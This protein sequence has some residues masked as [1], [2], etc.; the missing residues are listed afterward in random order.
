L[1][2]RIRK[3]EE[4]RFASSKKEGTIRPLIWSFFIVHFCW[5]IVFLTSLITIQ[6]AI[7]EQDLRREKEDELSRS[8]G[9][10][11]ICG[12]WMFKDIITGKCF[13][14]WCGGRNCILCSCYWR[15][16]IREQLQHILETK[17]AVQFLTLTMNPEYC[18][19]KRL[20]NEDEMKYAKRCLNKFFLYYKRKMGIED[21]ELSYFWV[22]E[23]HKEESSNKYPH[24]HLV[25]N[26][27]PRLVSD[28]K[29][30]WGRAGA[31]PK[32]DVGYE[33]EVSRG[34]IKC[35]FKACTYITKYLLKGQNATIDRVDPRCKVYSK[36]RN[37][38]FPEKACKTTK[39]HVILKRDYYYPCIYSGEKED[40]YAQELME[41]ARR[42]P[43]Q[44]SN[45]ESRSGRPEDVERREANDCGAT[46]TTFGFA[47]ET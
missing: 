18:D 9:K 36:S 29:D 38:S 12:R 7:Y 1:L 19:T 21:G 43:Y 5:G 14:F 41:S 4:P 39:S 24:F 25:L 26:H 30:C 6:Q 47:K 42:A 37:W 2:K 10:S 33:I 46:Q 17:Q 16:K 40:D 13:R 15:K 27:S 28:V 35:P 23:L 32:T 34:E 44:E 11:P 3:E 22:L 8:K 20:Y 31:G 45:E